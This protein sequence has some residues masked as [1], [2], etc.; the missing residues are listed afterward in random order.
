MRKIGRNDLCP[1]GS[2][3]KYKHC[4]MQ[5][6]QARPADVFRKVLSTEPK[7]PAGCNALG[8][9]ALEAGQYDAA[10]TLMRRATKGSPEEP[11]YHCNL[12]LAYKAAGRVV[13]AIDSL[14]APRSNSKPILRQ[15][16]ST[17]GRLR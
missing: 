3:K 4:C 9:I 11:A 6:D 7:D 10:I 14:R 13:E 17:G 15:R 12:G 16:A 1:C 5:R 2:G 8:L